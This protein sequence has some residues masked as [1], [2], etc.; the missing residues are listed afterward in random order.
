MQITLPMIMMFPVMAG[1]HA[2]IESSKNVMPELSVS[3]V[4]P[5]T[6]SLPGLAIMMAL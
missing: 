3:A 1:D 5:L 2:N 4:G 6:S